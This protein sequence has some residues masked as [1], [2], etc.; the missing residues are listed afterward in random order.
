MYICVEIVP[1]CNVISSKNKE[2]TKPKEMNLKQISLKSFFKRKRDDGSESDP[3]S[4]DESE[5][6]PSK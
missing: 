4:D 2:H 1:Y 6:V 3:P 5:Y